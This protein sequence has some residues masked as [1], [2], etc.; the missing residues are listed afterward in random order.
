M[1]ASLLGREDGRLGGVVLAC[2]GGSSMMCRRVLAGWHEQNAVQPLVEP[3]P[4]T[5]IVQADGDYAQTADR[6]ALTPTAERARS[7]SRVCHLVTG[8]RSFCSVARP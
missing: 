7:P 8:E 5:P 3:G 1:V 2:T 4:P 6:H